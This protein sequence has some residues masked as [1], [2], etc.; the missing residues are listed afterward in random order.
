MQKPNYKEYYKY[1]RLC[2]NASYIRGKGEK[3][4][5]KLIA[6]FRVGNKHWRTN[7]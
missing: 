4:E 3:K 5:R 2:V 6:R 1:I 7:T